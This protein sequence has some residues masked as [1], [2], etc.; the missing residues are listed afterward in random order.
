[1]GM[2]ASAGMPLIVDRI[3]NPAFSERIGNPPYDEAAA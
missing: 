1:M 2:P 3:A